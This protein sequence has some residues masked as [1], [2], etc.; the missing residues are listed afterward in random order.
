MAHDSRQHETHEDNCRRNP[1]HRALRGSLGPIGTF[2]VRFFTPRSQTTTTAC[3]TTTTTTMV[4]ETVVKSG[5][6]FTLVISFQTW[7]E[8][9]SGIKLSQIFFF[10]KNKETVKTQIVMLLLYNYAPYTQ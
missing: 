7:D 5:L 9:K 1:Q 10:Q 4:N 8:N 6:I 2:F 3:P